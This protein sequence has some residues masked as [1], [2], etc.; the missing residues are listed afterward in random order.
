MIFERYIIKTILQGTSVILFILIGIS[1]FLTF[2]SQLSEIGIN[3]YGFY[4]AFIYVL[5]KIPDQIVF[6]LPISVFIGAILS[7]GALASNNEIIVM[8]ASGMSIRRLIWIVLKAASIIAVFSLVMQQWVV[9][10]TEKDASQWRDAA[11]KGLKEYRKDKTIWVKEGNHVVHVKRLGNNGDAH[12]IQIFELNDNRRL[13]K[14]IRAS[15][16]VATK[17]GWEL[18]NIS[19]STLM[20]NKIETK[21]LD[22]LI[23]PGHITLGLLKS[24]G[25]EPAQ[26]SLTD[27]YQ[28]QSFLHKN[29]LENEAEETMFWRR[30]Y[31]PLTILVISTLVIPFI[32]GSQ[33]GGQTGQRIMIGVMI[34]L[35][36]VSVDRL[37]VGIGQYLGMP[38]PISTIIP[39][40]IFLAI[41]VFFMYRVIHKKD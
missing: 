13:V 30:M 6:S 9:T 5:L 28:Y 3:H 26:M 31:S 37:V 14:A 36:F 8:Q 32:L 21:K 34:G 2:I 40:I 39:M 35:S 33:R 27:L 29:G 20:P 25:V 1:G 22:R 41:N 19:E 17:H 12:D 23:Y 18:K 7:L 24:M 10:E 15:T 38:P 11:K 16:G 4:E